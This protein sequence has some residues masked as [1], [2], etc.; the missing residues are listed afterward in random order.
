M[1][2]SFPFFY[3]DILS[4]I[5]PAAAT[6]FVLCLFPGLTLICKI[7]SLPVTRH[8][9]GPVVI[10]FFILGLCYVIGVIYENLDYFEP[11]EGWYRLKWDL[12]TRFLGKL[13]LRN[14]SENSDYDAFEDAWNGRAEE[15]RRA[16]LSVEVGVLPES[17]TRDCETPE[18]SRVRITVFRK[19]LWDYQTHSGG[20]ETISNPGFSHSH[21]FQA[22]SK[23]FQHLVYVCVI[24]VTLSFANC[25][26]KPIHERWSPVQLSVSLAGLKS[27]MVGTWFYLC[28]MRWTLGAGL[29]GVVFFIIF[30]SLSVARNRRRWM[31]VIVF[32]SISGKLG[33]IAQQCLHTEKQSFISQILTF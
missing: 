9:W 1:E 12:W 20:T 31:Q 26:Y 4:R 23:M 13:S 24:L 8:D 25:A 18:Q 21:R 17:I 29:F 27:L 19:R 5:I 15:Y 10:P 16:G 33:T 14:L 2:K 7:Q 6:L 30:R 32:C 28:S 3:Y 22:E 11:P